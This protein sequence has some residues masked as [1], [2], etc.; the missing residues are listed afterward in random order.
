[1]V[2]LRGISTEEQSVTC[3]YNSAWLFIVDAQAPK[4]RSGINQF[5]PKTP[6]RLMMDGRGNDLSAQVEFDSFNHQLSPVNR[7]LANSW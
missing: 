1:M 6:I 2:R 3:W 4:A 5:L 7:H